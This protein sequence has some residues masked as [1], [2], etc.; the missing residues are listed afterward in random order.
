[1]SDNSSI[2]VNMRGG[3]CCRGQDKGDVALRRKAKT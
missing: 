3:K 1:M 2:I